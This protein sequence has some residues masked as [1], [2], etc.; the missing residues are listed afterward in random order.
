MNHITDL[1]AFLN[2]SPVNFWAVETVRQ[3]LEEQG[4][5]RL[6]MGQAWDIE[7]GSRH[8]VVQNGLA[9]FAFV[10]GTGSPRKGFNIIAAHSDSPGFRVKPR[11]EIPCEGGAVKLNTEVYG[12][13]ILYTW[14][15]RPLSLAGRV[16]LRGSSPLRPDIRLMRVDRP[17]LTIPHL[18]IHFNR[19]V[20]EGNPL[21]KQKD[22]LPVIAL[23]CPKPKG[24][25]R[26]LISES[27][28]VDPDAI[29]DYDM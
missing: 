23:D 14:F 22:M 17:M 4:F 9:I 3:R 6:D 28:D 19:A 29:L 21:S 10:A 27:L 7:P 13:P 1:C 24:L 16:A 25:V 15:D 5:S 18:A 26:M 2:A 20:N 12:G 8:Y 11:A